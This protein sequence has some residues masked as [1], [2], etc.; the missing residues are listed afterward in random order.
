LADCTGY[1]ITVGTTEEI[2]YMVSYDI[3]EAAL[4][5]PIDWQVFERLVAE[6][7]ALDDMPRLRRAGGYKDSGV[8]AYEAALY[9]DERDATTVIQITSQRA[10]SLKVETTLER[11]RKAGLVPR[12]ITFVFRHPVSSGLRADIARQCAAANLQCD[13]RDQTYVMLQLGKNKTGLFARYFKSMKEQFATLLSQPDPLSTVSDTTRHAVLLSIAA[14]MMH[15]RA[16]LV[17]QAL[18]QRTAAAAL[19]ALGEATE[20]EVAASVS[21]L[22]PEEDIPIERVAAALA[23]LERMG[24][25]AN[26]QGKWQPTDACIARFSAVLGGVRTA[27]DHMVATVLEGCRRACGDDQASLGVAERNLRR[28]LLRLFRMAG[29]L[30]PDDKEPPFVGVQSLSEVTAC[31]SQDLKDNIARCLVVAFGGY[32]ENPDNVASLALF[33]RS[34]SA[35][36]LR[37]IDPVGRRWQQMA[38]QRSVV[39]LDTD[40]AL[41]LLIRE[42]P[43]HAALQMGVNALG[44]QGARIVISPNVIDEVTGHI[45]RAERTFRKFASQIGNMSPAMV[46]AGIW[47]AVVRGY[48]YACSRGYA[49]TWKTYWAGYFDEHNPKE[50]VRFQL[51]GV[52]DCHVEDLSEIPED[53]FGDLE[54]LTAYIVATKESHRYKAEFREPEHMADRAKKDLQMA[55]H[56]ATQGG[57]GS[58]RDGGGY[59]ATEDRAF[60]KAERHDRWGQ[61]ARVAVLTRAIPQL[62]DFAC[63]AQLQDEDIVRLLYEP[64]LTAA[65]ASLAVEIDTLTAL[66]VNLK[67]VALPRLEWALQKDLHDAIHTFRTD[68]YAERKLDDAVRLLGLASAKG[69]PV[70]RFVADLARAY[71]QAKQAAASSTT[72]EVAAT[73]TLRRV[74]QA[75][76]RTKKSRR[77]ANRVLR[78]FGLSVT[79]LQDDQAADSDL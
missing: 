52:A 47:H 20:S 18:F 68:Q 65:A 76:A 24:D 37:N 21:S 45:E 7:L 27:Y 70:D 3:I 9:S 23:D 22:M 36:A 66:G 25:C 55:M 28:A 10:Q 39:A 62:A 30:G 75:L 4:S 44:Q 19:V 29:P 41:M 54:E 15:P 33:G 50:F 73:E 63:G 67:T 53:W 26:R 78:E 5:A 79:G 46:D 51:S 12:A 43:E 2:S 59:L 74:V 1:E 31:L 56:L 13:V 42:L 14:F 6:V 72:G 40:A 77:R 58:G 17:R 16:R 60:F 57:T 35:L 11:I 64:V 71:D 38:L 48:Y 61:R 32:V 69:L 49:G 34:Y 8:D